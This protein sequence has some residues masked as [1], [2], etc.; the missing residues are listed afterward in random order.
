MNDRDFEL[1]SAAFDH[2]AT[3]EELTRVEQLLA[4]SAAARLY[5]DELKQLSQSLHELPRESLPAEFPSQVLQLAERRSLLENP[6]G[7]PHPP[8]PRVL[9]V[10][11]GVAKQGAAKQGADFWPVSIISM[12]A[13]AAALFVVV[14]LWFS[15]RDQGRNELAWGLNPVPPQLQDQVADRTEATPALEQSESAV[16]LSK[17]AESMHVASANAAGQ[18]VLDQ[19]MS[20]V[21]P[22]A[23]PAA[24]MQDAVKAEERSVARGAAAPAAPGEGQVQVEAVL[25]EVYVVDVA[26]GMSLEVFGR[27]LAPTRA[28]RKAGPG[29]DKS[30]PTTEGLFVMANEQDIH[31]ALENVRMQTGLELESHLVAMNQLP[32]PMQELIQGQ[33]G[34]SNDQVAKDAASSDGEKRKRDEKPSAASVS[35]PQAMRAIVSKSNADK[36]PLP[37]DAK[38]EKQSG[39]DR[40]SGAD[41]KKIAAAPSKNRQAEV[42]PLEL[43]EQDFDKLERKQPSQPAGKPS[44]LQAENRKLKETAKKSSEPT[45]ARRILIVVRRSMN[46]AVP[47]PVKV[48]GGA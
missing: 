24:K 48:K 33:A 29:A 3:P 22:P 26:D 18:P 15:S 46:Q 2:E 28:L 6:E 30:R 41:G 45:A 38:R 13:T 7:K 44:D 39:G 9:P 43:S 1:L 17:E 4:T 34:M 31:E 42:V 21:P 14:S 10:T 37:A 16:H 5:W 20:V 47:Q 25:Y 12:L 23:P 35:K 11:H 27:T 36:Q 19:P 8:A 40:E 32:L